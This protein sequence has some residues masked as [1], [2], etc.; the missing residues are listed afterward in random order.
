MTLLPHNSRRAAGALAGRCAPELA[1]RS[2]PRYD[3]CGKTSALSIGRISMCQRLSSCARLS[4]VHAL[5]AAL[6]AIAAISSSATAQAPA[7]TVFEGARLI[8]GDGGT[9]IEDSIIIV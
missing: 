5:V 6:L 4:C 1:P 7:V 2:A 8:T 3:C 9:P